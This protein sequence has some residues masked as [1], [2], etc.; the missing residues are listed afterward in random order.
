MLASKGPVFSRML[1][2]IAEA[3]SLERRP[4]QQKYAETLMEE[5]KRFPGAQRFWFASFHFD[6]SYGSSLRWR[7]ER[8]WCAKIATAARNR[9]CLWGRAGC[10]IQFSKFSGI[11]TVYVRFSAVFLTWDPV[12][13]RKSDGILWW[14]H[15]SAYSAFQFLLFWRSDL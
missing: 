6:A 9:S 3:A 15:K 7:F 10:L 4:L 2:Q 12:C 13:E 11:L 5:V 8:D 14:G 1:R